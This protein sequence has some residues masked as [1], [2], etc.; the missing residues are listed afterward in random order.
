MD[1]RVLLRFLIKE[2][3][4]EDLRIIDQWIT[5]SP[6]NAQWLFEMEEIWY[7][8][9]ELKYSDEEEI[10]K[11]YQRYLMEI[12][13]SRAKRIN[14]R[15][16]FI[17][18]SVAAAVALIFLLLSIPIYKSVQDNKILSN[19]SENINVNEINVPNGQSIT[20]KLADGTV[21]W[22]NSGS[23]F[24]YPA[25]F[26]SKNRIVKLI[27]EGFF[28]VKH[29]KKSP[30]IVLSGSIRTK[31]LGTKFNVKAY[32]SEAI[33]ISLLE[34]GVEVSTENNEEIIQLLE[35]DQQVEISTSGILKKTKANTFAISQW[36]QGE[37]F[38]DNESLENIATTLERKYNVN[39]SIKN[40]AYKNMVLN[41]RI[42]NYTPLEDVLKVL[43]GTRNI[44]YLIRGDSVYIY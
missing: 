24:I 33:R 6:E 8:K 43:K 37:L 22:L 21:V 19:L 34:G 1:E 44:D 25:E 32:E 39:I 18:P 31:V 16:Y 30:F 13:R 36:T 4:P 20:V 2:C 23:R 10:R 14:L 15:K 3:T 35:P 38:F 27:G 28:E 7:L 40:D 42:K 41:S 12:D 9:T 26:S 29:N 5:A 17:Y 11:A